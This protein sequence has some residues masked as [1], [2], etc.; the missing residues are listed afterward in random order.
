MKTTLKTIVL[1]V[2][3]LTIILWA[4]LQFGGQNIAILNPKGIIAA[5]ERN[6]FLL[7]VFLASLIVAPTFAIAAWV[8]WKFHAR[9]SVTTNTS[10]TRQNNTLIFFWW[11]APTLIISVLAVFTWEATHKLDP[12]EPVAASNK[13][14]TIQVVALDW[15][16]LFIYPQQNIATVNFVQFPTHTPVTFELTADGPMNSFW[17]PQLGG[18][19]YA[20]S[21]M[22]T[23]LNLAASKPGEYTGQAAEIN[24][25]GF[26]GMRFSA[27]SSSQLDFDSWVASV[28]A[29]SKTLDMSEYNKLAKPSEYN[30]M[31]FYSSTEN[32]LFNKVIMKFTTPSGQQTSMEGM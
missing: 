19:M 20:M 23:Q 5:G 9:S 26:S 18:Q 8:V 11:A 17:I 25:S 14:L 28:K 24:G 10:D 15:K 32:D 22:G 12:F 21:G 3:L 16:W 6:L 7:A 4:V 1:F 13:P 27:K 29:S 31:D 30:R 2:L